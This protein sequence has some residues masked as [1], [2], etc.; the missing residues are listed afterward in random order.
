MKNKTLFIYSILFNGIGAIF[1]IKSTKSNFKFDIDKT[2]KSSD[3]IED[4][5]SYIQF[6]SNVQEQKAKFSNTNEAKKLLFEIYNTSIPKYWIGTKWD[7]N[8]T[9]RKPNKG[10]IACGYFVTNILADLGFKIERVKL[11]QDVSSKMIN[12][13][14]VNVKRFGDFNKLKE[15][16]KNQPNYSVF[17]IGLDYHT[18]YVLKADDKIYFLHSNY[19]DKEGVVKE[20]IDNSRA[21]RSSKSYMIGYLSENNELISN[22]MK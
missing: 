2:M 5:I 8:G 3:M 12:V 16:I 10:T 11:A 22:W 7:F 17:I 9:T 13:L 1:L 6:L 19:I 18:G 4:S 15:Y 21:L 20:E 14:C